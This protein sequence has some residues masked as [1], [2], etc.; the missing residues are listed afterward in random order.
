MGN[1]TEGPSDNQ[2]SCTQGEQGFVQLTE[3]RDSQSNQV[4]FIVRWMLT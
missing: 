4:A 2:G 1:C 3:Q